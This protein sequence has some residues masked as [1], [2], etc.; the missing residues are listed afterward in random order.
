MGVDKLGVKILLRSF[1]NSE[2]EVAVEVEVAG[3]VMGSSS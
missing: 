1:P 3:G 2:V